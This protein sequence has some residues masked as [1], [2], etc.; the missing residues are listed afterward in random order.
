WLNVPYDCGVAIV[1]DT[2]AHRA[3]MTSSAA[4]LQQTTGVERDNI[5]WS[6]EF[7]QRARAATVYAALRTLG[8]NG[9]EALVDRCCAHAE[10][11]AKI[12]SRHRR[13]KI[14]NDVTLNQVLV[15]FGESDELTRATIARVQQEGTCW[16][17]GT[18]WHG[19]AAMRISVSHWATSEEDVDR[20]AEAILGCIPE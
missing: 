16:L 8:R 11:F 4:Y 17:G 1:R 12:L 5:D 10:R 18:T 3:A 2:Q 9:V 6:P 19:L 15:R 20:S 7:S 14:L 13:V